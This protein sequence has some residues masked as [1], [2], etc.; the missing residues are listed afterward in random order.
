MARRATREARLVRGLAIAATGAWLSV[1]GHL[2]GGASLP[3]RP[4]LLV[5]VALAAAACTLLSDREWSYARLLVALGGIELLVHF[6][7]GL[8][9]P[10]GQHGGGSAAAPSGWLMLGG[11]TAAAALTAWVLRGGEAMYWRLVERLRRRPLPRTFAL[12]VDVAPTARGAAPVERVRL[13]ILVDTVS[14]RGPPVL[15]G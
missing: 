12:Q 1:A 15:V 3:T 10:G 11:H 13:T 14:R 5:L 9:H 7:L 4:S 6:G 2:A 8:G